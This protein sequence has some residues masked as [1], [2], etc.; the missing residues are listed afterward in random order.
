[1]PGTGSKF[2]FVKADKGDK[3]GFCWPALS[4]AGQQNP[5]LSP[6]NESGG[7]DAYQKG[8]DDDADD[9]YDRG[10]LPFILHPS[11]H[12]AHIDTPG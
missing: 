11:I 9:D 1:M 3:R 2:Y 10:S 6:L 7:Y 5:L 4:E 12:K 8:Y